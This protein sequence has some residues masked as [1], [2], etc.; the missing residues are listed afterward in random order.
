PE[1]T[2]LFTGYSN[3]P[4]DQKDPIS[5]T[6]AIVAWNMPQ[7]SDLQKPPGALIATRIAIIPLLDRRRYAS[8]VS[9]RRLI[10]IM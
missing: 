3:S 6:T 5:V 9:K 10:L 4:I 2:N 1:M 8:L 7:A